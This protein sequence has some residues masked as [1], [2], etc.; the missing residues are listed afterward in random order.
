MTSTARPSRGA[1]R[2]SDLGYY[3]AVDKGGHFAA[4]GQPALFSEE[5]RAAFRPLRA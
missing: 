1:A 2:L 3:N 5:M 4:W